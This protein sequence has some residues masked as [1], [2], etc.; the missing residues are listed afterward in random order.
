MLRGKSVSPHAG[1]RALDPR[2]HRCE[3]QLISTTVSSK[4]KV[5]HDSHLSD[6]LSGEPGVAGVAAPGQE[7]H[8]GR[9]GRRGTEDLCARE[10]QVATAN[11]DPNE[12][13][14]KAKKHAPHNAQK[15]DF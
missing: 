5:L 4:A 9:L 11:K 8:V 6:E 15:V 2:R 10:E 1:R 12:T 3:V 14:L 13:G 7:G